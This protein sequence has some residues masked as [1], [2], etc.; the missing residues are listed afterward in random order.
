MVD[1]IPARAAEHDAA[2]ATGS[3][4]GNLAR[5]LLRAPWGA[6]GSAATV[7]AMGGGALLPEAGATLL[8]TLGAHSAL[9]RRAP[10]VTFLPAVGRLWPAAPVSAG[11]AL[12]ALLQLG[13]ESPHAEPR[14]SLAVWAAGALLAV[15]AA[16]AARRL[17]ARRPWTRV[18][19]VGS[20]ATANRL[21]ADL[22]ELPGAPV[23]LLGCIGPEG[24]LG[25]VDELRRLVV[26]HRIDIL[27]L[28]REVPAVEVF[29]Q[30]VAGSLEL[31]VRVLDLAE[32]YELA[33]GHV[34][35]ADID[36]TWWRSGLIVQA[37]RP[38]AWAKRA[39]DVGGAILLGAA[40][41]PVLAVI[42]LL[43]R[44]DGG[45]VLFRQRRI[46][47]GGRPFSLIKL[48]TMRAGVAA[49]ALWAEPEDPRITG[50]GRFLRRTHLDELPQLVNVLRGDMSLVGPR[51]EQ[52]E[53]VLHL[54]RALPFYQRRHLVRPGITG[55]GQIRSGYA[56]SD[57]GSAVKLSHDLYYLEHRC[58]ALDLVILLETL[59]GLGRHTVTATLA[60]RAEDRGAASD[61]L[62]W[63]GVASPACDSAA[64]PAPASAPA[65][66]G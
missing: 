21:D 16:A 60:A 54:E 43:I 35:T 6:L 44:R 5:V 17:P 57:F 20:P 65:A 26:E 27:V 12:I 9:R 36:A 64:A 42:A 31:P 3:P 4:A 56:R 41:L 58:F 30:L 48:R 66:D 51:P 33:F 61:G 28:S 53:F 40:M 24:C 55:W 29:E 38:A 46:G 11:V 49:G 59:L 32:S 10:W 39:L 1:A 7:V 25:G 18:A 23:E 8:A 63:H 19:V 62:I 2:Q 15:L 14:R 13:L 45:P 22:G 47:E 52:P 37:R 34:P 50:I